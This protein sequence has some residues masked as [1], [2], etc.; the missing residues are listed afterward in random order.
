[1][2]DPASLRLPPELTDLILGHLCDALAPDAS[3]D[4]DAPSAAAARR[5]LAALARFNRTVSPHAT[6]ALYARVVVT[7]SNIGSLAGRP[8]AHAVFPALPPDAVLP[9]DPAP[10]DAQLFP[11][12]RLSFGPWWYLDLA[13][14]AHAR[15]IAGDGEGAL[16]PHPLVARLTSL[17]PEAVCVSLPTRDME[18]AYVERY[19][20]AY[21]A[22]RLGGGRSAAQVAAARFAY[23]RAGTALAWLQVLCEAWRAMGDG[24]E[25]S[26]HGFA[27]SA[28]PTFPCAR[29]RVF[30]PRMGAAGWWRAA[31]ALVCLAG[32]EST[33]IRDG[34]Y[35][36]VAPSTVEVAVAGRAYASCGCGA[37]E[38]A[39]AGWAGEV[40]RWMGG[41]VR[42]SVDA[43]ACGCCG[44]GIGEEVP[45]RTDMCTLDECPRGAEHGWM[46][47]FAPEHGMEVDELGPGLGFYDD[48]E[49][50]D[51]DDRE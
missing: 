2:T 23:L 47:M 36:W 17:R 32:D 31:D 4:S 37:F 27:L 7:P 43:G 25:V 33:V 28:A 42:L 11:A 21:P 46:G 38:G 14:Y 9:T 50:E 39:R 10:P 22:H 29:L 6:R 34:K 48:P 13:D 24:L 15:I 51:E 44:G 41:R 1:M 12:T 30:P 35:V 26:L 5:T 8:V 3:D 49:D 19:V 20:R 18:A 45:A 16:A 40:Q